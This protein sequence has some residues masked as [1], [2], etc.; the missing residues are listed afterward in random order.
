MDLTYL[1]LDREELLAQVVGFLDLACQSVLAPS[2]EGGTSSRVGQIPQDLRESPANA[3]GHETVFLTNE[4]AEAY[5]ALRRQFGL[6]RET[7]W[8]SS[9]DLDEY[10]WRLPC[11]IAL[12]PSAF[13]DDCARVARAQLLLD[14]ALH[15]LES[16]EVVFR[17]EHVAPPAQPVPIWDAT[18]FTATIDALAPFIDHE[19]DKN[20]DQTL[21]LFL[22]NAVIMVSVEGTAPDPVIERAR[23]MAAHRLHVLRSSLASHWQTH[24]EQL[25]CAL[26]CH[27]L[28]RTAT[29]P[30]SGL[31]KWSRPPGTPIDLA[32]HTGHQERLADMQA[33]WT[34][35]GRCH[36]T[37][38]DAVE[39]A[40]EWI[41]RG[42]C[43]HWP[44][45]A[46][47]DFTTAA[48]VLLVTSE[49]EKKSVL[50][51]YRMLGLAE[52]HGKAMIHPTVIRH[53]YDRRSLV[54]HQGLGGAGDENTTRVMLAAARDCV[55]W[56]TSFAAAQ[57]VEDHATLLDSLDTPATRARAIAWLAPLRDPWSKK[58]LAGIQSL[59]RW[60]PL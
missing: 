10:L 43:R 38:R 2:Q 39:R 4:V 46:L 44:G 5:N 16:H 14:S 23:I 52:L 28:A 21:S 56:L 27:G 24:P 42:L 7:E 55:S 13:A 30:P 51:P 50:L 60:R 20:P 1:P 17:V 12:T 49:D 9:D 6:L 26:G 53:A 57:P 3:D 32:I 36:T 29:V 22:G 45:D 47:R 19:H 59:P 8:L 40:H 25:L 34:G 37:V 58:L 48:E 11:E 33:V 31:V 41:G 35:L 15:A 18:L 54:I